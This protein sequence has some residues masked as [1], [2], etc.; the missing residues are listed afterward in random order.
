MSTPEEDF[1]QVELNPVALQE[2]I[3]EHVELRFYA[4]NPWNRGYL[5]GL[6]D[7]WNAISGEH[8]EPPI[9]DAGYA[10][11][12]AATTDIAVHA[13]RLLGECPV[14]SCVDYTKWRQRV[15]DL[16]QTWQMNTE[17]TALKMALDSAEVRYEKDPVVL[18]IGDET[19]IIKKAS[20]L[21][22]IREVVDAYNDSTAWEFHCLVVDGENNL[23][24]AYLSAHA[25]RLKVIGK[26]D[27]HPLWLRVPKYQKPEP[28]T[29]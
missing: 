4:K 21:Y 26:I 25:E 14:N 5:C 7:A 1:P 9:L 13:I 15:I 3:Q 18:I 22:D 8:L 19:Y 28:C 16:I 23:C 20:D 27:R 10:D 17:S 2:K 12:W 11:A 24:A 29:Q 6:I